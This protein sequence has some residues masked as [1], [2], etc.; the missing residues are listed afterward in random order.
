MI[1][2]S[3]ELLS[4]YAKDW[5]SCSFVSMDD[6]LPDFSGGT[7]VKIL[8]A[9]AGDVGLILGLGKFPWRRRR[10]PI[11]VFLPGKFHG[12]KEPGEV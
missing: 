1:P 7:V 3:Q 2:F 12:Q 6:G 9:V 5:S 4:I 8:P 10:Q 11:A